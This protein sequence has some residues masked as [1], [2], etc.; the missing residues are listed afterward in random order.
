MYFPLFYSSESDIMRVSIDTMTIYNPVRNLF[1]SRWWSP[2]TAILAGR[3][4]FCS[5]VS[6]EFPVRKRLEY[7]KPGQIAENSHCC[8][9]TNDRADVEPPLV[10]V[11]RIVERVGLGRWV[12]WIR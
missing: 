8:D 6:G 2:R 5:Q 4:F 11:L 7:E 3:E 10:K 12:R 1:G 9:Q